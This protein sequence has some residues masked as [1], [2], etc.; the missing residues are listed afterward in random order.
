MQWLVKLFSFLLRNQ[1]VRAS[2]ADIEF[3]QS[4][5]IRL[6]LEWP[7]AIAGNHYPRCAMNDADKS[8]VHD[9]VAR[10]RLCCLQLRRSSLLGSFKLN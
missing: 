1:V 8:R 5:T 9:V 10:G 3:T 7:P 4:T 6:S 2:H